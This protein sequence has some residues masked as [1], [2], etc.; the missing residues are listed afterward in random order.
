MSAELT[1]GEAVPLVTVLLQRL[2]GRQG[3][4]S[5][6]I[7]G[8][9]F[10]ELG[11]RGARRSTDVDILIHPE[12]RTRVLEILRRAGWKALTLPR[13]T[14]RVHHAVTL[15]HPRMV[16]TVDLHHRFPGLTR[17][18]DQA[19]ESLWDGREVVS[20]A[21]SQV[22]TVAATAGLVVETLHALRREPAI[23]H[24]LLVS[25]VLHAA[26]HAPNPDEI[27][28]VCRQLGATQSA[29]ALIRAVGGRTA[30]ESAGQE[31][32][33]S[34]KTDVMSTTRSLLGDP[35]AVIPYLFWQIW[36]PQD[37]ARWWCADHGIPFRNRPQVAWARLRGFAAR[38]WRKQT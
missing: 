7:K 12:D 35:F 37:V 11:V 13:V 21:G 18:A 27:A 4:R 9:A 14:H 8:P 1:I 33:W 38:L 2:L 19:F 34:S 24:D 31:F 10:V 17:P 3:V 20:L 6:A 30:K 32:D 5:L 23:R 29:A 26:T 22:I 25:A 16:A 28:E 36:L 15:A